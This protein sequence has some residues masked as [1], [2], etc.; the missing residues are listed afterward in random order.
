MRKTL[1]HRG[2]GIQMK[3]QLDSWALVL[4]GGDGS[5]LWSL[6]Q[7]DEGVGVPKQFRCKAARACWLTR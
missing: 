6:T 2:Q 5:R 4:A 3:Y 7:N 1:P